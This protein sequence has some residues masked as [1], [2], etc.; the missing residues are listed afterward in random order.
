MFLVCNKFTLLSHWLAYDDLGQQNRSYT[1]DKKHVKRHLHSTRM[2]FNSR[3]GHLRTQKNIKTLG[4]WGTPLG[5]LYHSPGPVAGSPKRPIPRSQHLWLPVSALGAEA[6][7]GPKLYCC[8]RAH[9]S[10]ASHCLTPNPPQPCLLDPP[11]VSFRQ[12][13]KATFPS[14]VSLMVRL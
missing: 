5:S 8:I 14:C 7:E 12:T 11:L 1:R 6:T 13:F 3:R 10:L 9:Q 2:V 4:G